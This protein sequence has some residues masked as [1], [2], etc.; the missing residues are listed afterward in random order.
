MYLFFPT[1]QMISYINGVIIYI[2]LVH[3]AILYNKI[4]VLTVNRTF[5][6]LSLRIDENC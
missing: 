2:F 4:M 5:F 3:I 1:T 6:T